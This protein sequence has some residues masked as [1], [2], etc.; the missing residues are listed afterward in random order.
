MTLFALYAGC[1]LLGGIL[2]G[3]SMLGGGKDA[4]AQADG[5]DGDTGDVGHDH[6][7]D[8][9]HDHTHDHDLANAHDGHAKVVE[10]SSGGML[11]ATLLSLRFW[12]FAMAS[13]G[14]TGALFTLLDIQ[15]ILGFVLATVTGGGVGFGVTTLLRNVS[16]ETVSSALDARS[17]RGRDADVVLAISPSKLGK[18]RLTHNGQTIELPATTREPHLFERS[19]RVIVVDVVGGTAEITSFAPD[20]RVPAPI[21]T[22]S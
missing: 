16:R 10:A 21:T 13:F 7:H 2:I 12:T 8:V 15:P 5:P 6:D 18:I 19:V 1:L 20:R 22:P 11:A 9:G 14:M 4:D 3:A 17:L